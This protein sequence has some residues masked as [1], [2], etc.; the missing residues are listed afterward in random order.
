MFWTKLIIRASNLCLKIA[1]FCSQNLPKSYP[2]VEFNV[3]KWLIIT[4]YPQLQN[5][6]S[7]PT[8]HPKIS[9]LC[10]GRAMAFHESK[11]RTW[12]KVY[13]LR[14]QMHRGSLDTLPVGVPPLFTGQVCQRQPLSKEGRAVEVKMISLIKILKSTWWFFPH[15][16]E[17]KKRKSNWIISP[18]I[19]V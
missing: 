8:N 19:G 1:G 12:I 13:I 4:V 7:H 14:S 9:H 11:V 3:P 17:K 15:P 5:I 18:G 2:T 10:K 6:Q 16:S